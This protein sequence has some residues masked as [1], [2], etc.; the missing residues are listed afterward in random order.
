MKRLAVSV[1]AL[2]LAGAMIVCGVHFSSSLAPGQG[3][4]GLFAFMRLFRMNAHAYIEGIFTYETDEGEAIITDCLESAAGDVTVPAHLGGLPVSSI[5]DSAFSGLTAITGIELPNGLQSIGDTAFE[6]CGNLCFV[7]VPASVTGIGDDVLRSSPRAVIYGDAGSFA[8]KYAADH[9][10]L[11]V[12]R[13]GVPVTGVTIDKAKAEA[14]AGETL[15]LNACVVPQYAGNRELAWSSSNAAI[16][17][18]A[19]DGI[20][21][22]KYPGIAVITTV[23][24]DGGFKAQCEVTVIPAAPGSSA[25]RSLSYNSIIIRWNAVPG[26]TGYVVYRLNTGTSS[27]TR[28][29]VTAGLSYTDAGLVTGS[30]YTYKVR[31]YTS[32]KTGNLYGKVS[33]PLQAVPVPAVPPSFQAASATYQSVKV[34]WGKV[35]GASGYVVYRSDQPDAG[36]ERLAAVKSTVYTNNGLATGQMAYYKVRAYTT[37]SS[38]NIYGAPSAAS[39]AKALPAVPGSPKAVSASYTS[40]SLTWNAVEGATGYVLYRFNKTIAAYERIKVTT[41]LRVTDAGRATGTVYFYKVRS[42]TRVGSANIYGDPSAGFTGRAVPAAP[43]SLLVERAGSNGNKLTWPSVAGASGYLVY[44]YNW[45][46]KQ[47]DCIKNTPSTSF[48]NTPVNPYKCW[49]YRVRAYRNVGNTVVMGCFSDRHAPPSVIVYRG[50]KQTPEIAFTFD[51]SGSG[52]GT[53]LGICN[54]KGVK[55]TFFLL[56]GELRANPQRWRDAVKQGHQICNHSVSH[57]FSL[58]KLSEAQIRQDILGW[59]DACRDVLGEEYLKKMKAE[60]PYFRSPGGNSTKRL[61][62]VLGDLGYPVTAYWSCEDVWFKSHNPNGWT[63]SQNY[64]NHACNGAIF[65]MHGGSSG[66]LASV[67]DGV[68][69]RGYTPTTFSAVLN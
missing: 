34:S 28:I 43:S 54:Q 47:Y 60:F 68:R 18:V 63:L 69:A 44:R 31:A 37:V 24:A 35:D 19:A 11:F 61:Q 48:T 23:T 33:A 29:K 3:G 21:S 8:E 9:D 27:Y 52:L 50:S 16:A 49:Y 57:N 67:I 32:I 53:I 66:L 20:V 42:Y 7:I 6:G 15:Q 41:A 39:G 1:S 14:G 46:T 65:L 30:N 51:D 55:A 38:K 64:I 56:A 45:S 12:D 22:A 4:N 13:D 58:G 5:G 2:M 40:I 25:A 17:S 36:F 62:R 10:I 59:E 26:A